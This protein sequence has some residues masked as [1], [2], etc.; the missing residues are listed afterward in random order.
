M[1][2]KLFKS[3]SAIS[4]LQFILISPFM[5]LPLVLSLPSEA[6]G[7]KLQVQPVKV[8]GRVDRKGNSG[9]YPAGHVKV[10][11]VPRSADGD[12]RAATLVYTGTDGMYYFQV[13]TGTYVLRVWVSDKESKPFL[14]DVKGAQAQYDVSPIVIP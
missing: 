12:E 6:H 8:R 3:R 2:T 9:S 10:T 13:P 4:L 14:I 5:A 1:K 11:I 7:R